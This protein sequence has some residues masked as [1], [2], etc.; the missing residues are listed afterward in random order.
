MKTLV[1]LALALLLMAASARAQVLTCEQARA[2]VEQGALTISDV[3]MP[4]EWAETGLPAGA[5]GVSLQDSATLEVRPG[6]VA[7]VLQ[8]LGGD[9]AR[10]IALICARGNRSAVARRLLAERGFSQVHDISEGM[11]G[12]SG[13]PGWLARELPTEP[14]KLC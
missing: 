1:L 12:G 2:R 11:K 4:F 7:D 13:G 14:C 9:K 5:A 8:V 6:F 3:R 10:P